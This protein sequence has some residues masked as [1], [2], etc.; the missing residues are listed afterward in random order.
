MCLHSVPCI[1]VPTSWAASDQTAWDSPGAASG[2]T[3]MLGHIC[4]Q[5]PCISM[6]FHVISPA[7]VGQTQHPG[8]RLSLPL[9]GC[10]PST[11]I[12]IPPP[13]RLQEKLP[14]EEGKVETTGGSRIIKEF[15]RLSGNSTRAESRWV[16]PLPP[17]AGLSSERESPPAGSTCPLDSPQA[18][19]PL[20]LPTLGL[21]ERI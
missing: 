14:G 11:L 3:R 5:T 6:H 15:V 2:V 19:Y 18:A 16:T 12:C 13:S 21:S 9:Q 20:S 10:A 7:A 17:G 1:V 8:E 4:M